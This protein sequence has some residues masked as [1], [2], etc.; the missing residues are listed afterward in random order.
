MK[1]ATINHSAGPFGA[2]IEV[3]EVV[4]SHVRVREHGSYTIIEAGSN[5]TED[6]QAIAD[7][8]SAAQVL[9]KNVISVQV[10]DAAGEAKA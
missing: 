2:R 1:K 3:T 5:L 4:G 8:H 10:G 9:T 6:R 7:V